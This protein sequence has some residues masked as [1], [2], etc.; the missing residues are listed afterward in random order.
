M[1]TASA[2]MER[3]P[4]QFADRVFG[5]LILVLGF[6]AIVLTRSIAVMVP[7]LGGVVA[8]AMLIERAPFKA[9]AEVPAAVWS[10]V[11]LLAFAGVSALWSADAEITLTHAGQFLIVLLLGYLLAYW[12]G[13]MPARQV[14]HLAYWLTIAVLIGLVVLTIEVFSGQWLRRTAMEFSSIFTPP[15]LGRHYKIAPDG[16]LRIASFELNRSIAAA[17]MLLW[18][19]LLCAS[20][21]WNGRKL[22]LVAVALAGLVLVATAASTHET[23][24]LAILGGAAAFAFAHLRRS[25]A[26]VAAVAGWAAL[27]VGIVPVVHV[28]HDYMHL[29]DAAWLQNS[30]RARIVIWN[31]VADDWQEAPLLGVGARTGYVLNERNVKGTETEKVPRHAHN[32]YLQTWYELGFVGALLLLTAGLFILRAIGGLPDSTY[33]FALATFAVGAAELATSWEIW[34]RWFFMLYIL[35]WFVLALALRS[36]KEKPAAPAS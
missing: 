2:V 8:L 16:T 33:P 18:P 4:V 28:A 29:E 19:M 1:S 21:Y 20:S 32:V 3:D 15:K 34:Q 7:V 24:K 10:V 17:N 27:V 36:V 25:V 30:A 14:R 6:S 11:A 26:K 9:M 22:T 12:T 35:T 23:S 13:V 31:E 5:V